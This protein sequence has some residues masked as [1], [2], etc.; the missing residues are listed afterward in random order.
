M[1]SIPSAATV[2]ISPLV[3]DSLK[4]PCTRPA[5]I[6]G[7]VTYLWGTSISPED[8]NVIT[9]TLDKRI[10]ISDEGK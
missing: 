4:L 1:S 7:H 2:T 10:S 9:V 8:P 3:G 5:K 6:V